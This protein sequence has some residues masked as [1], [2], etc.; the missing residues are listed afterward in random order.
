MSL[1][2]RVGV[3]ITA[4]LVVVLAEGVSGRPPLGLSAPDALCHAP[5]ARCAALSR[6][7]LALGVAG[8]LSCSV[9][10]RPT[11]A[12]EGS[13]PFAEPARSARAPRG[14]A[15]LLRERAK[16]GVT[17]TGMIPEGQ[18]VASPGIFSDELRGAGDPSA[19]VGVTFTFPKAW[20]PARGQNV[21]VRNIRTSDGAFLLAL[22]AP[23]GAQ[24]VRAL[25]DAFF[26]RALFAPDG[27]FGQYGAVDDFRVL[28]SR[29]VERD[30]VPYATLDVRFSALSF[31]YNLVERRLLLSAVVVGDSV[32]MLAASAFATRFKTVSA[33]LRDVVE[34]YRARPIR[35]ARGAAAT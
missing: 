22:R 27:K 8:A 21:D 18:A 31:N 14:A 2:R 13:V 25:P 32:Y 12:A 6:R 28:S 29:V 1:E 33:Q 24:S 19:I 20:T 4:A 10:A 34:S 15:A 26:T 11:R 35:A 30:G 9:S 3:V 7:R 16:T 5:P 17:R 23:D